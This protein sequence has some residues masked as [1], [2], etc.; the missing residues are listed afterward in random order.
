MPVVKTTLRAP[1]RVVLVVLL[2]WYVT[3]VALPLIP[4]TAG[5][6][7]DVSTTGEA[8]LDFD[9]IKDATGAHTLTNIRVPNVTLT[10]TLTT[11]T[12]NTPQ[13]GDAFAR[14]GLAGVG[15]TNLGDVRIGNLD[16]AMTTRATPAQVN[17]EVVDALNV[18]TYAEPTGVPPATAS[19]QAKTSRVYQA[20]RNGF[21][22]TATAKTF[23]D[24]SAVALWKKPL[25]DDGTTYTEGEGTTP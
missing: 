3:P 15:L 8:G 11:Y 21:T 22:V 23:Q 19:I 7:L 14:I 20:L 2:Y 4:T 12:G 25:S 17:A 24:D 16:A 1:E 18:D 6:T 10:D 5:R 13:T 9:N